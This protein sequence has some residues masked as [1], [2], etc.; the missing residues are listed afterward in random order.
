VVKVI[1]TENKKPGTVTQFPAF[2]II[3]NIFPE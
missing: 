1:H 3:K 2:M